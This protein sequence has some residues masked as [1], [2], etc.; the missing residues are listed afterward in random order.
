M[1]PTDSD[2]NSAKIKEL[3]NGEWEIDIRQCH[4]LDMEGGDFPNP[5]ETPGQIEV[6]SIGSVRG[7]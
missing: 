1:C 4:G 3:E 6:T 7:G 5:Y 2:N